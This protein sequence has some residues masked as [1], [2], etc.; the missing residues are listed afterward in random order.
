[1]DRGVVAGKAGRQ[2]GFAMAD[3]KPKPRPAP[4]PVREPEGEPGSIEAEGEGDVVHRRRRRAAGSLLN[5]AIEPAAAGAMLDADPRLDD[6]S[7]TER[8]LDRAEGTPD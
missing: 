6:R 1:M 3:R 2:E 7:E 5:P 8:A 4:E